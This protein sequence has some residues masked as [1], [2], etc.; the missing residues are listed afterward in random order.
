MTTFAINYGKYQ[1]YN[2]AVKDQKKTGIIGYIFG[3]T[4]GYTIRLTVCLREE[5]ARETV[6]RI[7]S[8]KVWIE[9]ITRGH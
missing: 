3:T 1:T 5:K 6:K 9:E 7:Q 4:Q 2:D 8:D